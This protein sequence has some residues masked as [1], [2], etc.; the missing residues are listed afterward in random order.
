M[1]LTPERLFDCDSPRYFSIASNR[2]FLKELAATLRA[3]IAHN[4]GLGLPDAVIYLP[5][6]RAVRALSAAFVETAHESGASLLPRIRALGDIDEDELTAFDG[7]AEDEIA[8][9]PAISSSERRLVLAR[10]V[11]E[12]DKVFFDGQQRWAGAIAAA[13]ALGKLLDS[14]YTEEIDPAR[15][16]KIVPDA[17]AEHWRRSL[18]FL[19]IVTNAWP[20][21]LKERGLSDPAQR[22]IELIDRQTERWRVKP[23]Q[24]PIIIAGTTGSTPAVARMMKTVATL[25]MGCVVLPG[26]DRET[27]PKV[28]ET[29]D[30]PHPQNGLKLLLAQLNAQRKDVHDWPAAHYKTQSLIERKRLLNVALTPADASDGWRDWATEIARKDND[31]EAALADM[32]LI[33]ARDEESEAAAIAVKMRETLEKN[34]KTAILATPDRDLARRVA[35]KMRRW[36]VTVD[37]SAGIPLASSPCGTFLRLTAEWLQ[38]ISDPVQLMAV[39]DHPLFGGG[40]AQAERREAVFAFDAGLRGL[41]PASGAEGLKR[42]LLAQKPP[43]APAKALLDLIFEIDARWP[44]DGASFQNRFDAHLAVSEMLAATKEQDGAVRLWGGDDGETAAGLLAQLRDALAHITTDQ[45]LDYADIF[46]RL[47]SGGV[48]RRKTPAHPRLSILGP[49]EARLQTADIVILGGLNEGV[50]PRDAAIDPFLS[51]PM[52]KTL[53]LPSPEQRIGLAAH[54]FMQLAAAPEV[55]LTRSTRAGGKPTKPS[56]WIVRLKNILKGAKALSS[57]ERTN[58]YDALTRRLD[59]P[60]SVKTVK[61][62]QPRPPLDA[63]PKEFFVTHVEKLMRDPYAVY[64]RHILG[65][66]KLDALN[67][68]FD[69]R[70]MGNLF[71]NVL[72]RYAQETPPEDIEDCF[73]KLKSIFNAHADEFGLNDVRQTYWAP[74]IKT[75]LLQ[76][77]A[78][79]KERRAKGAPA[80]LEENGAWAFDLNGEK[81]ALRARADRIDKLNDG[82]AY[83]IDYK[84]GAPPTLAQNKTFSPQ[85]PLTGLIANYGG[86]E[87][88]GESPVAGFEYH[89]ILNRKENG[90]DDVGASGEDCATLITEARDGLF[91][92]LEHFNNADASYPSQPRAQYVDEYGDYDHLARRRERNAQGGDE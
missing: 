57:I 6:R 42:K 64:A 41:R 9:P 33:E 43:P 74:Q 91:E 55:M 90:K 23:P 47:I 83:I 52:R 38:D 16:N 62:P 78:W 18:D 54:D 45:P 46:S 19:S 32:E 67:E 29:V 49:L 20:A 86:F 61:A 56:R 31:L 44:G 22:R 65:L 72:Q 89:R 40:V 53:G 48:V 77:A 51:R 76:F 34:G 36:G 15:L 73:Q 10:L 2:Y 5:T 35:M 25:P 75:A 11:S 3:A 60:E 28:W 87:E 79:D 59:A 88:L 21:F 63:R 68:D 7:A 14:L 70:H 81:Y 85:L 26:L 50:W 37:D 82:G 1:P 27:T 24:T 69:A 39:F 92:L 30:E 58:F 17:L 71:H 84:T 80:V 13:D 66:K 4:P 12:R 8:V